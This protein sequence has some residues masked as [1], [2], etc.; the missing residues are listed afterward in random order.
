METKVSIIIPVYNCEDYIEKCLESI[1]SQL[2]KNIEIIIIN[3]GSTDNTGEIIKKYVYGFNN[4]KY[5][6]QKNSGPSQARNTG[7]NEATGEYLVFVDSDD[8]I[9]PLYIKLLY[10]CI[11]NGNYDIVCCGYVDK[12]C[13]GEVK[14]NDFWKD[15]L[16]IEKKMFAK[17]CCSGVGGV[18]WSK[19]FKRDIILKN[20]IRLRKDI[21]MSED[22]LFVLEYCLKAERFAAIPNFLY[23]YNRLNEK[24]ISSNVNIN[25]MSNNIKVTKEVANLLSSIGISEY[26]IKKI[27]TD[28]VQNLVKSILISEVKNFNSSTKECIKKIRH[29]LDDDFIKLYKLDFEA[30]SRLDKVLNLLIRKERYL[31][32]F[33]FYICFEFFRGIKNKVLRK[34]IEVN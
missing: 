28:R 23:Q 30:K 2:Y 29:V 4:I 13:Y 26:D 25:Y 7:I 21:F 5:I 6:N 10:E 18:L 22:L 19:I 11:D 33:Y 9:E 31:E 32:L 27:I 15:N 17:Y 8:T 1:V 12:S 24:S 14:L 16:E 34:C 20:N 3:D